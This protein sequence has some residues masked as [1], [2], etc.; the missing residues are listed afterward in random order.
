MRRRNNSKKRIALIVGIVLFLI[1]SGV[2]FF[3]IYSFYNNIYTKKSPN[4][5]VKT[6]VEKTAYNILLMGYGGA[7]HEGAYLTD[8]MMVAHIDTKTKKA[9]LISIPR[10]IWVKVPTDSGDS[11]HSKINAV[12]QMGLFPE[13]YPDLPEHYEGEQGAGELVGLVIQQVTGLTVDNYIAI[14]FAGFEKTVNTLG[15]IDVPVAVAFDDPEYPLTGHEDDLCGKPESEL[16]ELEKIATDSPEIAFP[17]R[18][19]NLHF[20]AG[21]QRMDGATALKF[22]R[23]R[24]SEQDGGDFARARRQQLFLE[25]LKKEVISIGFLPKII[26]LMDDLADHIHTDV[27]PVFANK[28]LLGSQVGQEYTQQQFVLDDGDYI[29]VGRSEIGQFILI[30]KAGIDKW[31]AVHRALN[32][33]IEGITPV[34]PRG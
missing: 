8:T 21:T 33:F 18:Y 26:P 16:P 10:D 4:I 5:P 13:S 17:C 9:T 30:P 24:H 20:S 27:D 12:Y 15:G 29:K 34:S 28:L 19:E 1:I 25:A 14:D 6:P 22:V 11:F 3:K 31:Q 2:I 23:S 7:G 32:N